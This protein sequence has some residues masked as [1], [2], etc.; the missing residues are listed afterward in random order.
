VTASESAQRQ[1][2]LI[3]EI[4]DSLEAAG[5]EWWLYGGWVVDFLY[6]S[7]TREHSD[8]EI[9]IWEQDAASA[10]DALTNAG[11]LAPPGLHPDEG[12]PFLKEGVEINA[13]YLRTNGYGT[14]VTPGRWADWPWLRGSFDGPPACLGE[15][16]V[17]VISAAA[18]LDMKLRFPEHPHGAAWREK[19][20]HDIR[21]LREIV[22][23]DPAEES[24]RP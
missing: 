24:Q 15:T 19:D 23:L 11:F 20:H 16:E 3:R 17:P 22:A 18:Q 7:I 9:F 14:I 1:L 21:V 5:V 10:R 2:R 8:I 12:Q 6:G 4:R 13:T